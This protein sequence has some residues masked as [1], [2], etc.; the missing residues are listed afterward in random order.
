[1]IKPT[2]NKEVKIKD[3]NKEYVAYVVR[4]EGNYDNFE[5]FLILETTKLEIEACIDAA[6]R[7]PYEKDTAKCFA[8]GT[9]NYTK[10]VGNVILGTGILI[11]TYRTVYE[12]YENQNKF[13]LL[14]E[15][16]DLNGIIYERPS[17]EVKN[18]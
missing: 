13:D 2:W 3:L 17:M 4:D 14:A 18:V 11:P 7:L 16:L 1:M 12:I 5:V 15:I 8:T 6:N 10:D 9:Y